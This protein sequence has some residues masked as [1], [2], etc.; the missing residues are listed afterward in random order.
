MVFHLAALDIRQNSDFHDKAIEQ[1]LEASGLKETNFSEWSEEKRLEFLNAEL[2]SGR[3]FVTP[4]TPLGSNATAVMD[5]MRTLRKHTDKYGHELVLRSFIVSMTRS[6]SDLL[7][8]Y[9]LAR[10]AGRYKTNKKMV[11]CVLFL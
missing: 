4:N 3:P 8:V 6:L 2:E 10:E 5:C 1:L 9:V 11:L 7:V